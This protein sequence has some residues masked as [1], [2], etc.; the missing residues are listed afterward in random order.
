MAQNLTFTCELNSKPNRFG[1]YAVLI[2]IT[3]GK[4]LKR[5][6]TSVEVEKR[7]WNPKPKNE[8][9]VRQ[10]DIDHLTKNETLKQELSKYRD[11]YFE[12]RKTNQ[13]TTENI[14]TTLENEERLS[15]I[16]FTKERIQQLQESGSIRNYKRYLGFLNKLSDYLDTKHKHKSNLLFSEISPD[17]VSKFEGYLHTLTNSRY[18][19]GNKV[20][21]QNT[22]AANLRIF[23]A[24]INEALKRGYIKYEMN[25][26]ISYK[27]VQIKTEKEKLDQ[28]E[29]CAIQAL[30]LPENSLDWNARNCFLFSYYCAG[31]RAGDLLLLRWLNVEGG[32]LI[33]QMGKNHKTRNLSLV[34]QA[35]AILALYKKNDSKPNDFI[36]PF[37]D[38]KKPYSK[39]VSQSERDTLPSSLKQRLFDDISAKNALLNKTLKKI[40]KLAGINKPIS[41]HLARHSFAKAAM[42]SGVD[43]NIIKNLLA[44]SRLQTTEG[45][46]GDFD[47]KETDK[48]LAHI[49]EQPT[50]SKAKLL[51][52]L[53]GMNENE[54]AELLRVASAKQAK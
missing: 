14:I 17:F 21:H 45:Y 36:F 6:K 24:L 38:K 44:H 15:F 5:V 16:N 3:Q 40:A 30:D 42:E 13:A 54:V 22:I 10:G 37:L 18:K 51:N 46:M 25:P 8:E 35:Q 19:A 49:F 12:L 9:W 53:Q 31:I 2:R 39:A 43:N 32:R 20:L 26:F 47:S 4:K 29:L 1:R 50:D 27:I 33:Y 41:M 7:N 11:K 28:S 34:P 23:R 52:L 48:A